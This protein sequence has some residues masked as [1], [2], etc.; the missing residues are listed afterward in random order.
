MNEVR[1]RIVTEARTWLGTPFQ[2]QGRVKGKA[3]DCVGLIIQTLQVVINHPYKD[4]VTYGRKPDVQ[5][6]LREVKRYLI[7]IS[8]EESLPGDIVLLYF[9]KDPSH[10]G[11]ITDKGIIHGYAKGPRKVV[12]HGLSEDWKNRIVG[13]FKIPGIDG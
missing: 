8:L 7:P 11:F 12:E 10:F 5:T 2:H 4:D 13:V 1:Q 6:L 3:C 9:E